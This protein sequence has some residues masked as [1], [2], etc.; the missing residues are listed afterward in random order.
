MALKVYGWNDDG[1]HRFIVAAR[2]WKEAHRLANEA[3]GGRRSLRHMMNYGSPTGN[4]D[5]L[6][7]ALAEPGVV[8]KTNDT[9]AIR[10]YT[11]ADA[12]AKIRG[13]E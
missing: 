13:K 12:V 6:R 8:F 10:N 3:D 2:S 4:A 9:H 5:E 7:I 1:I 11:R